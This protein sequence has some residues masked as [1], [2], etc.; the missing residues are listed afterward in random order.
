MFKEVP[1]VAAKQE[2]EVRTKIDVKQRKDLM[3]LFDFA[4]DTLLDLQE[5]LL[6]EH[7]IGPKDGFWTAFEVI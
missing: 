3:A 1:Q 2:N 5:R 7:P 4:I 6:I